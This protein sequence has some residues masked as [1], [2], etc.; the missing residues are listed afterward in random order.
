[1]DELAETFCTF[2]IVHDGHAPTKAGTIENVAVGIAGEVRT[3][4]RIENSA[5]GARLAL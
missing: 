1:M 5:Q 4:Q 2:G 3:R